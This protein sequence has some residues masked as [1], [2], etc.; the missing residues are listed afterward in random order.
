MIHHKLAFGNVVAS[1]SAVFLIVCIT[2]C[3]AETAF[4]QQKVMP[5]PQQSTGKPPAEVSQQKVDII[6]VYKNQL[7]SCE[8]E[9]QALSKEKDALQKQ[10]KD[11]QQQKAELQKKLDEFSKLRGSS[12][13]A[14]CKSS[15]VSANT[16]GA[17]NECGFTGYMCESVSG[18]CRTSCSATQNQCASG[19]V[20][21]TM[22]GKCVKM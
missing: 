15:T 21:D 1:L 14:Y 11:L 3:G 6:Q 20:C 17:T 19:F 8:A 13:K 4:C 7:Q 9:R 10:N 12:V 5:A 18:L 22:Y 16:A 2:L